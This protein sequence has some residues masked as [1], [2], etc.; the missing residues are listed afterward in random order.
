MTSLAALWLPI[1]VSTVLIFLASSIVH[2]VLPWH[3]SDWAPVPDEP[4]VRGALAPMAIAPGDYIVPHCASMQEMGTPEYQAKLTEGPV[5]F[6]TVRPNAQ[7]SMG[8]MF[9]GWT[10]AVLVANLLAAGVA[11]ATIAPGGDTHLIW[12][13]TGLVALGVYGFGGW[14]EAIWYGRKWS[15]AMK[16]TLDGAIYAVITALTFGWLWPVA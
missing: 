6:M 9:I 14:P 2:M 7:P 10:L 16:N 5:L 8:P 4:G 11:A 12:H 15:T 3:K 13:T 1:V